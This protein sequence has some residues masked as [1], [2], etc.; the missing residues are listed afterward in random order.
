MKT[1]YVETSKCWKFWNSKW[2]CPISASSSSCLPSHLPAQLPSSSL[3]RCRTSVLQSACKSTFWFQNTRKCHSKSCLFLLKQMYSYCQ[4]KANEDCGSQAEIQTSGLTSSQSEKRKF[5]KK[6]KK[7]WHFPMNSQ[8]SRKPFRFLWNTRLACKPP[9]KRHWQATPAQVGSPAHD[10][11]SG[12]N[13]LCQ[14]P[15]ALQITQISLNAA[16]SFG[17]KL[18]SPRHSLGAPFPAGKCKWTSCGAQRI[19]CPAWIL[20]HPADMASF[21]NFAAHGPWGCRS[22]QGSPDL[23]CRTL[24]SRWELAV[25]LCSLQAFGILPGNTWQEKSTGE[26][27]LPLFPRFVSW[28]VTP[29]PAKEQPLYQ[30]CCEGT[31]TFGNEK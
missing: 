14:C 13:R 17:G 21:Y 3:G 23:W 1:W 19:L 11:S 15:R 25:L 8:N 9:T 28:R 12:C 4:S 16:L 20:S 27:W 22:L 2:K 24:K 5:I 18:H 6:K 30:P 29:Q 31:H 26:V 10:C 7:V